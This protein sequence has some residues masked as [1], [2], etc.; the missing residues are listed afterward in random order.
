M[1]GSMKLKL[2]LG[3]VFS[4]TLAAS[5]VIFGAARVSMALDVQEQVTSACKALAVDTQETYKLVGKTAN[6]EVL[7]QG[8][9][10]EFRKPTLAVITDMGSW[11]FQEAYPR[12][13]DTLQTIKN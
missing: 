12:L 7:E 3:W 13:R 9:E 6:L 8:C 1:K 2:D 11:S 5:L 10:A 4:T